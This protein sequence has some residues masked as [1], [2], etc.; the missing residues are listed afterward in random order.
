MRLSFSEISLLVISVSLFFG[1]AAQQASRVVQTDDPVRVSYVC[2]RQNGMI[3]DAN[4]PAM[5]A[6]SP[7][8]RAEV[9]NVPE[10][11]KPLVVVAGRK[12]SE[13]EKQI[14]RRPLGFK[15][16]LSLQLAEKIVGL[17]TGETHHLDFQTEQQRALHH[18]SRYLSL[19]RVRRR[20]K[21]KETTAQYYEKVMNKPP[22]PG[23][24]VP[25]FKGFTGKVVSVDGNR[26]IIENIPR[27]AVMD[28]GFGS[29]RI[30]DKGDYFSIALD[31]HEGDLVRS[32]D[33][34]GRI[35]EVKPNVFYIDFAHP[36]GG[37]TLTC[38]VILEPVSS[39]TAKQ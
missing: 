30:V 31:V 39:E 18:G 37:E 8:S 36:Y 13:I 19:A 7:A 11:P 29:G 20:D 24:E 23:D 12:N 17:A 4:D 34:Y 9:F 35:V 22:I 16:S 27:T 5:V 28:T 3:V 10:T 2:M 32:G 38:D 26:V 14:N 25:T 6:A 15:E 1:C 21:Y 33:N